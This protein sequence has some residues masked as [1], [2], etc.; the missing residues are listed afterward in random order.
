MMCT[1]TK[2]D[3][4]T[5]R[6]RRSH[7]EITNYKESH[8]KVDVHHGNLFINDDTSKNRT[9]TSSS[10]ARILICISFISIILFAIIRLSSRH[11]ASMKELS[12]QVI[13]L[14]RQL[15]L[16]EEENENSIQTLQKTIAEKEIELAWKTQHVDEEKKIQK[17]MHDSLTKTILLEREIIKDTTKQTSEFA[18]KA[19]RSAMELYNKQKENANLKIK[20]ANAAK[21]LSVAH[22]KMSN[23][24]QTKPKLRGQLQEDLQPG[25]PIE[26]IE[27]EE[28]GKVALRPGILN[29]INSDGT[30]N[31]VKLEI[32]ILIE[33]LR[34]EQFQTYHVY[35][36]NTQAFYEVQKDTYK[37]VTIIEF[38][39][40][41]ARS[42]FELHGSYKFRYDDSPDEIREGRAMRLHRYADIGE[43]VGVVD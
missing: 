33:G 2:N 10:A 32:S 29:E 16:L 21:E 26:L 41:S 28:G 31:C 6:R 14:N 13:Q 38:M 42:G 7:K 8:T 5:R 27:Y 40:G 36:E 23:N 18:Q 4:T 3:T 39:Q 43:E 12:D 15:K 25:H 11:S 1:V 37:P 22:E 24:K 20:L 9:S 19:Q 35:A 17:E 30:F 34:R